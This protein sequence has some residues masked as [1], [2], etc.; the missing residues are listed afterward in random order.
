MS[1]NLLPMI[2]L[3]VLAFVWGL[4]IVFGNID[5]KGK[6]SAGVTIFLSVV[7]YAT[8]ILFE[9][10][11]MMQIAAII[12]LGIWGIFTAT[13]VYLYRT[14]KTIITKAFVIYCIFGS[15]FIFLSR[16][17]LPSILE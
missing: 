11:G 8:T 15:I 1:T 12:Y 10:Y 16:V 14:N 13:S 5:T 6:I 3:A 4:G 17:I 9:H 2:L 7:L